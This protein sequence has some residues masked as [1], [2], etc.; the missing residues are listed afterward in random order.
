MEDQINEDNQHITSINVISE[1]QGNKNT[2]QIDRE[3][4]DEENENVPA[5]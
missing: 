3:N 4:I 1:A 5:K 2:L